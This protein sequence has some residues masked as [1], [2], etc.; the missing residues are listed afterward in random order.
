MLHAPISCE[1]TKK[2]SPSCGGF[3]FQTFIIIFGKTV[4][5]NTRDT[6]SRTDHRLNSDRVFEHQHRCYQNE[7]SLHCV[8]YGQSD[9][10]DTA[11]CHVHHLV[12][13][14]V[15]ES[16]DKNCADQL[17][18]AFDLFQSSRPKRGETRTFLEQCDGNRNHKCCH[19]NETKHVGSRQVGP[20]CLARLQRRLRQDST[21]RK[22]QVTGHG[23][24]KCQPR[25]VQ[26]FHASISNTSNNG[27]Q[28]CVN[29][30]WHPFF[31]VKTR[32]HGAKEGFHRFDDVCER[33]GSGPES[34]HSSKLSKHVV[35]SNRENGFL[36]LFSQRWTRTEF[37]H[38]NDRTIEGTNSE[39]NSTNNQRSREDIQYLLVND[40]VNDVQSVPGS[41]I[42]SDFQ[43]LHESS[44]CSST[45]NSNSAGF[46]RSTHGWGH[47]IDDGVVR[48]RK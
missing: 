31:E 45:P 25:E 8:T 29:L 34:N 42:S 38:P 32:Y 21:Q 33:N 19:G 48:G 26:F 2:L 36:S 27:D 6:D 14:V 5:E 41:E 16:R 20:G 15:E 7:D 9:R 35:S 18:F 22:E 43:S 37:E 40:V 11:Q 44:S 17:R 10:M 3:A 1:C 4:Q 12:V 39:L 28:C 30:R 47:R 46:Q 24:C 13:E 23:R